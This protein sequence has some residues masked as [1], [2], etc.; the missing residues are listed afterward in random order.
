MVPNFCRRKEDVKFD[1]GDL[2]IWD[3]VYV[4]NYGHDAEYLEDQIVKTFGKKE[5]SG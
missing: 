3:H 4:K 5:F 1:N 2:K